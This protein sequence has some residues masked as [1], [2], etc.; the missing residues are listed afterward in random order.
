MRYAFAG[1]RNISCKIL[2]F[3]INK[4]H[5]PLALFVSDGVNAS[6]DQELIDIAG[7]EGDQ[8]FFGNAFREQVQIEKLKKLKLD[9]IIGIHF[10][11]IIPKE[12]LEIPIIGFL[13]LHPAYLPFNKGW[14]TPSWA[15]LEKSLF[16]ATLHFMSESLD[17]G[18]I[19]HQKKLKSLATDTAN[20]LYQ[21][22]LKLEEEVF[23]EAY[24]SLVS[25]N[26][27]RVPQLSK[28]TTHLK[29]DLHLIQE[30]NLNEEI[31]PEAFIDKLR[32]MTTNKSSEAAY[33]IKDGKRIG[34][35]VRL[36][37]LDEE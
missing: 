17:E 10:P 24:E 31:E 22:T 33:F 25:L 32:A 8:I 19:I 16:G 12:V 4:G 23:Y 7:L 20:T 5:Q 30:I 6:H 37:D 2:I 18:E 21:R 27:N 15:I 29:R 35:Q 34:V 13:N 11:Y 9:Y 26:P 36:F 3:L 1:D 28:G 14:H